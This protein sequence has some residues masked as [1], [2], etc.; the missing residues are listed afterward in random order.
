[1]TS[2]TDPDARLD[3]Q[4]VAGAVADD[5]ADGEH[6][7]GAAERLQA[8]LGGGVADGVVVAAEG[9]DSIDLRPS[10]RAG[11]RGAR[12]AGLLVALVTRPPL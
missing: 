8:V 9:D 1:M 4:D 11:E 7:L 5:L 3:A 6:G 10:E 12:V 2:T